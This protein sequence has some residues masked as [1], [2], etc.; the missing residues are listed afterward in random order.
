MSRNIQDLLNNPKIM[1][2]GLIIARIFPRQVGYSL[3][4]LVAKQIV[5][6]DADPMVQAVRVN[7]WVAHREKISKEE[8]DVV[9]L[10]TFKRRAEAI[11]DFFHFL[12]DERGMDQVIEFGD[13][14]DLKVAYGQSRVHGTVVVMSHTGA[15]ELL[16]I[17]A[18][19]KG[20]HGLALTDPGQNAGYEWHNKLRIG[21]GIRALPTTGDTFKKAVRFLKGG[22]TVFTGLERPLP[23]SKYRPT[24]FGKPTALPVHYI[25]MALKADVPV[26]VFTNVPTKDRKY[27]V[28]HSEFVEME[29][30][31]NRKSEILHNAERIMEIAEEYIKAVPE[32][33]SMLFPLWPEL[34][35][36]VPK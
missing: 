1:R 10:N 29:R 16:A 36:Q 25:L 6:R 18:G 24:F 30:I 8:L 32:S 3:A 31:P 34:I 23:G 2:L 7:Q 20:L 12:Y 26:V 21:Y 19:R 27:H 22:G 4:G 9:V 17:A 33:W 15:H 5:S 28:F 11:F 13:G 14:F 35:D